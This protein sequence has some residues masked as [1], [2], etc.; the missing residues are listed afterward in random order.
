[1]GNGSSLT[2]RDLENELVALRNDALGPGIEYRSKLIAIFDAI[3]LEAD[4]AKALVDLKAASAEMAA[5]ASQIDSETV[6]QKAQNLC[7]TCI[8]TVT[9]AILAATEKING[10]LS[11]DWDSLRAAYDAAML[12]LTA[13]ERIRALK[14]TENAALTAAGGTLA[15]IDAAALAKLKADTAVWAA[16]AN[17]ADI[18]RLVSQ[19]GFDDPSKAD[20]KAQLKLYGVPE[21]A[22]FVTLTNAMILAFG[23]ARAATIK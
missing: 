19:T 20:A 16:A 3:K 23:Q 11:S 18:I 8:D 17:K 14:D 13:Y 7:C 6:L 4:G 1:M 10:E 2:L 15:T 5:E 22:A 12:Y 21:P 9:G